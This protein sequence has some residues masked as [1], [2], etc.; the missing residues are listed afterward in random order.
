MEAVYRSEYEFDESGNVL[1]HK[2]YE[3][4]RLCLVRQYEVEDEEDWVRH[5]EKISIELYEDGSMY[6][7]E[8]DMDGNE[9]SAGLFDEN[10]DP[11]PED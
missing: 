7:R 2:R 4:D 11:V 6:I 3:N 5:Y 10:G 8:F 1:M 9:V